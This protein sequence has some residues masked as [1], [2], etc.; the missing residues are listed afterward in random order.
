MDELSAAYRTCRDINAS[1]GRS[2]YRATSL[3]PPSRRPH[4]WALYAVA[5]RSDDL[6]DAPALGVDPAESLRQWESGVARA[7]AGGS[8]VSD[9]VLRA[10]RH[11]VRVYGI[12]SR[13]FE[14]FFA[15]MRRDL[16]TTRYATW[17]DLRGYMR[18]SAAAIGE[19][20]AP[21]LGSGPVGLPQA[22][23]LGEAFQ[24]TNFIRDIA[25]DWQRGRIYLP[26]E[27]FRATGC[28]EDDLGT[29]VASGTSSPALRR[30]VE[31]EIA[32]ARI[33][34]DAAQ[35]GLAEVD[36]VVRPCLR[37][38]FGLYSEI[39]REIERRDFEVCRGRVVVP[40]TRR[41]A[42]LTHSLA[43][44]RPW[45]STTATTRS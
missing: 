45:S 28:T 27:D 11:T 10:L 16:T 5:R 37:A 8:G 3:L 21:I 24:L 4:V 14:E 18:G 25:E 19:M 2:F 6:V 33:L 44:G 41:A 30:L 43:G 42:V 15:S 22:A 26:L 35:P 36:A 32:R 23:A 38:A 9:P 12:P 13:L 39:L 17:G 34:Y 31:F 1:H 40:A 29:A 7:V 20:T